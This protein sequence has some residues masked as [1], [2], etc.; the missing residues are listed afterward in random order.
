MFRKKLLHNIFC[1]W[2]YRFSL[3]QHENAMG[4]YSFASEKDS[5]FH[6]LPALSDESVIFTF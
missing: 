5:Y 1:Y 4:N 3:L 6:K 2:A